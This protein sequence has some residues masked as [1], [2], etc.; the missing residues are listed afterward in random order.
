MF[1]DSTIVIGAG[2]T[3]GQLIPSL[4]RLL[5]YHPNA[6]A[7][8]LI[9]DG[10]VFEDHNQARQLC[11]PDQLG[12]NKADVLAHHCQEIGLCAVRSHP[13]FLDKAVLRRLLPGS[14]CP[15]IVSAVDNDATRKSVID[16]LQEHQG[17]WLHV[18]TG[19]ADDSDGRGRIATSTH[20]HGVIGG[21]P[22]G[23]SPAL[24]FGNIARPIDAIPAHGTCAAHAPSAPQ[25]I[26]ANA[27]S[28]AMALLVIQNLLDGVMPTSHNSA[29]AN[30]RTFQLTL[31]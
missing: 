27:L 28:A 15:L 5:A 6:A 9:A 16:V 12:R 18:T 17:D 29:F 21:Q 2:G 26:S 31:S 10:D 14:T 1:V 25:L 13:D 23:L 3:G 11:G 4:A 7:H 19:N 22:I 24:L 8:L 20:W 30:G